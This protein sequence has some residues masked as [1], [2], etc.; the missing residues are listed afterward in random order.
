MTWRHLPRGHRERALSLFAENKYAARDWGA[1][2]PVG[3]Q[4]RITSATDGHVGRS[5]E[6]CGPGKLMWLEEGDQAEIG[7]Q[8]EIGDRRGCAFYATMH[9]NGLRELAFGR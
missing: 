7:G 9:E 6:T 5:Y 4:F 2:D 8:A 3:H 1:C